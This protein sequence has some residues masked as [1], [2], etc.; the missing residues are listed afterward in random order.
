MISIS[1]MQTAAEEHKAMCRCVMQFDHHCP[2]V[3]TCVGARNIRSFLALTATMHIAQ[4]NASSAVPS[5]RPDR[6]LSSGCVSCP[7]WPYCS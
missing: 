4:V 6:N 3:F 1:S 7:G 5:Y 2:V